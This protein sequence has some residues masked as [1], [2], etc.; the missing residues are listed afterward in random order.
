MTES[1][2]ALFLT[3]TTYGTWL[4]G[5]PRGHVSN[6]LHADLTTSPKENRPGTPH[7]RP[8]E[9]TYRRAQAAQKHA[10]AWLSGT[11]AVIAADSFVEAASRNGWRIARG[12]VMANHVHLV[13]FECPDDGPA[14]RRVLKGVSQQALTYRANSGISRRWWTA[15]GSDRYLHD[16]GSIVAAMRYVETQPRMLVQIKDGK[17]LPPDAP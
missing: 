13:V 1:P 8:H 14:V 11:H 3:W 15:G 7:S 5:D 9:R 12:A 10:T 17:V 6:T 2:F 4:P 16:E